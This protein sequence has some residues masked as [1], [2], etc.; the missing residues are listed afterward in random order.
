MLPKDEEIEAIVAQRVVGLLE[1]ELRTGDS[2]ANE[3]MQRFIPLGRSLAEA[4]EDSPLIA[5]LLDDYY[6][7]T[8]QS[9]PQTPTI[10]DAPEP[11]A[12]SLAER[13]ECWENRGRPGQP[14]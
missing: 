13:E 10:Q 12:D 5:R 1:A 8:L 9:P 7:R 2:L 11:A 14:G 3:R 6:Q 4:E